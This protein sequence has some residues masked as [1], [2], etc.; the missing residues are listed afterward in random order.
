MNKLMNKSWTSCEQIVN[1]LAIL[2]PNVEIAIDKSKSSKEK[3]EKFQN[4]DFIDIMC[5]VQS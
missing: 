2:N 5:A 3:R 4:P 1:W